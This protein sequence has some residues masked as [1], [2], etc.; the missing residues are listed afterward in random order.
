MAQLRVQVITPGESARW[1]PLAGTVLP[2]GSVAI[3]S[4][5]ASATPKHYNDV[6]DT[7]GTGIKTVTFAAKT[8]SIIVE[9]LSAN[10][11]FVSFDGDA[12]TWKI[13]ANGK[14][15]LNAAADSLR[16]S[17]SVDASPYQILTTE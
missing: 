13:P 16:I 1:I 15:E 17:A 5:A 7:V 4:A 11:L 6:A 2:D 12:N 10:D 14:L 8:V 9:N 3:K